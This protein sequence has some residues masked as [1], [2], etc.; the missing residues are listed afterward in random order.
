M[1]KTLLALLLGVSILTVGG[2]GKQETKGTV[3]EE[4]VENVEEVPEVDETAAG[5]VEEEETEETEEETL[6]VPAGQVPDYAKDWTEA[7]YGNFKDDTAVVE[8]VDGEW[9]SG[10]FTINGETYSIGD[11]FSKFEDNGWV[12]ECP[13]DALYVDED[14]ADAF[15]TKGDIEV[16]VY[17]NVTTAGDYKTAA[18][19]GFDTYSDDIAL[20]T[21]I[22]GLVVGDDFGKYMDSLGTPCETVITDRYQQYTYKSSDS[23]FKLYVQ[24]RDYNIETVCLY[25]NDEYEE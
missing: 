9:S 15:F 2:C 21:E 22:C 12:I 13:E 24:V 25:V 8:P 5:E 19:T 16:N 11:P 1:K 3:T 23:K 4:V 14:V 10:V 18:L 20:G 17:G 6:G 7:D